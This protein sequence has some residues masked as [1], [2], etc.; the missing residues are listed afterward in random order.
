MNK[1]LNILDESYNPNIYQVECRVVMSANNRAI[2]EIISDIRAIPGI[3]TVNTINSDYNTEEGRHVIDL[4]I[5]VDPSPFN[6][7]DKSSFEKILNDM[8]KLPDIRGA[9]FTSSP[10]ITEN[11]LQ[12]LIKEVLQ[13]KKEDRCKRI[14][15]RR[16]NKPSAYKSGAIVRCRQGKIW[17]DLK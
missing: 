15:D 5:K 14:A 3:T 6:P 2:P 1:L 17:K 7:F 9:K 10:I 8:K 12:K 4:S 11:R 16:Y 13:E